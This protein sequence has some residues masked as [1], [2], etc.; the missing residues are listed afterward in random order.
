MSFQ[1]FAPYVW[2]VYLEAMAPFSTMFGSGW[3]DTLAPVS[4]KA[5]ERLLSPDAVQEGGIGVYFQ[6]AGVTWEVALYRELP[7]Q[8]PD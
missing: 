3:G 2:G 4:R 5:K 6:D 8:L 7:Q 1:F